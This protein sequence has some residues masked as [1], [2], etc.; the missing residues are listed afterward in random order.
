MARQ[1]KKKAEENQ[2]RQLYNYYVV[3]NGCVECGEQMFAAPSGAQLSGNNLQVTN[4]PNP[5]C[6]AGL[7]LKIGQVKKDGT[8]KES[9]LSYAIPDGDIMWAFKAEG[10][11]VPGAAIF[12]NQKNE[13]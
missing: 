12:N 3:S 4:C 5:T 7:E 10:M 6:L 9:D 2:A 11:V 13:A 8:F 1:P